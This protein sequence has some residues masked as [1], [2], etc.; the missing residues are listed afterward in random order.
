MLVS[1]LPCSMV[2]CGEEEGETAF[3]DQSAVATGK[4]REYHV[5]DFVQDR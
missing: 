5:M 3:I 2:L 4:K 1:M